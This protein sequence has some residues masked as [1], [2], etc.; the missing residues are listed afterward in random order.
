MISICVSI[1]VF[2]L[3]IVALSMI[4]EKAGEHGWKAVIPIYN[5]YVLFKITKSKR[6]ALYLISL[7][8]GSILFGLGIM[9]ILIIT[10]EV[11]D[12]PLIW[13]IAFTLIGTGLLIMSIIIQ[14]KML[15]RLSHCFGYGA[16]FTVLLVF[17][18]L[19]GYYI[20][21]ISPDRFIGF[22]NDISID[23]EIKFFVNLRYK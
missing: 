15:N 12:I 3:H 8:L 7:I 17:L 4:F 20:L 10:C 9:F 14:I 11:V 5:I 23:E 19:M 21:G 1:A 18:P 13:G 16:G 2:I 22:E 6:F